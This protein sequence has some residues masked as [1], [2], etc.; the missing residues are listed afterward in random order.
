VRYLLFIILFSSTATSL[1]QQ[2]DSFVANESSPWHYDSQYVASVAADA[3]TV[4]FS[5]PVK[6]AVKTNRIYSHLEVRVQQFD[7]NVLFTAQLI[8]HNDLLF[9]NSLL[10]DHINYYKISFTNGTE[11]IYREPFNTAHAD[12][13]ICMLLKGSTPS[14]KK[15]DEALYALMTKSPIKS[16]QPFTAHYDAET[17]KTGAYEAGEKYVFSP[18]AAKRIIKDLQ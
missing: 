12:K 11:Y 2:G 15:S 17:G 10:T 5:S 13:T 14:H 3:T 8:K 4:S 9:V 6:V 18:E 1:A 16:I 7:D